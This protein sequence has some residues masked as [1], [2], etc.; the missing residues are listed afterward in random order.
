MAT[1]FVPSGLL[2]GVA[3]GASLAFL[4]LRGWVGNRSSDKKA[5][6]RNRREALISRWREA[7]LSAQDEADML[8]KS[9]SKCLD[10]DNR[11]GAH[12]IKH[13]LQMKPEF[14]EFRRVYRDELL[15]SK[16][17][18]KWKFQTKINRFLGRPVK[19][20]SPNPD[21]TAVVGTQ[22]NSH[23][24]YMLQDIA[25]LERWWKLGP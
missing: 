13:I 8:E 7:A 19:P 15:R 3:I 11:I 23:V 20:L 9:R 14:H 21:R 1:E 6:I 25:R 2:P 16:F 22:L 17:Y 5:E 24:Y 10:F 18:K 12:E 4:L